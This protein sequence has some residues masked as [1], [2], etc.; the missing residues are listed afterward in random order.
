MSNLSKK[1]TKY[2]YR[3]MLVSIFEVNLIF[4]KTNMY[5]MPRFD[6]LLVSYLGVNTLNI[7]IYSKFAIWLVTLTTKTKYSIATKANTP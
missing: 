7:L 4:K 1:K 2:K 3:I 5:S 6:H